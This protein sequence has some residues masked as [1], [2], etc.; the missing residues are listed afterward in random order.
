MY[1]YNAGCLVG[2]MYVLKSRDQQ[3]GQY[4]SICRPGTYISLLL[5]SFDTLRIVK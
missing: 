2:T 5:A 4:M 3:Y 1:G